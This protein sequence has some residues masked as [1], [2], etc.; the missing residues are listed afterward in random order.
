MSFN[1]I[2]KYFH[3]KKK[4]YNKNSNQNGNS[5]I[6]VKFYS[7]TFS[8]SEICSIL[9]CD[10]K[11]NRICEDEININ[12][13]FWKKNG[14]RCPIEKSKYS[15]DDLYYANSYCANSH[16][17]NSHNANSH[18]ANSHN[19]NSHNAISHNANSYLEKPNLK[20][21][22]FKI[23]EISTNFPELDLNHNSNTPI[24]PSLSTNSIDSIWSPKFNFGKQNEPTQTLNHLSKLNSSQP[25]DPRK[26]KKPSI[27][28]ESDLNSNSNIDSNIDSNINSNIDSNIDSNTNMDY[29]S[30]L[31]IS[32]SFDFVWSPKFNFDRQI[33]LA[34][35]QTQVQTQISD[36]KTDSKTNSKTDSIK[37]EEEEINNEIISNEPSDK[38][39]PNTITNDNI[40]QESLEEKMKKEQDLKIIRELE[41]ANIQ[42]E[43]NKKEADKIKKEIELKNKQE[44]DDII[45]KRTLIEKIKKES[46]EILLNVDKLKNERND[47]INRIKELEQT[48]KNMELDKI[49]KLEELERIKKDEI[50]LDN[51]IRIKEKV[52]NKHLIIE[53]IKKTQK[54]YI[55]EL[56]SLK[57]LKNKYLNRYASKCIEIEN[58]LKPNQNIEQNS[59]Y[60]KLKYLKDKYIEDYEENKLRIINECKY[61]E[62]RKGELLDEIKELDIL[63]NSI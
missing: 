42:Y 59:D 46:E 31:S 50:N 12:I 51:I 6:Y 48:R 54:N 36:S 23:H 11:N 57:N 39:I 1:N 55:S 30:S 32:P 26:R 21:K 10:M 4:N 18:N 17:A 35:V 53:K 63:P 15:N 9:I 62:K 33:G 2:S 5:H 52:E 3:I 24:S 49:K 56:Y 22:I 34:Q 41:I 43:L 7:K 37:I 8:Y 14:Y 38:I 45:K 40:L 61:C 25:K 28:F 58:N 29:I 60:N 47:K 16:N 27:F 20:R 44:E 19:A 13:I